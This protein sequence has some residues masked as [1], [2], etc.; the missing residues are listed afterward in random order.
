MIVILNMLV[1]SFTY[2]HVCAGADILLPCSFSVYHPF[3]LGVYFNCVG[4]ESSLTDCR[5]AGTLLCTFNNTARVQCAGE[6]VTGTV[7]IE[8]PLQ[9]NNNLIRSCPCMTLILYPGFSS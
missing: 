8:P 2:M 9:I 6:T 1:I 7:N 5:A 3:P 4:N